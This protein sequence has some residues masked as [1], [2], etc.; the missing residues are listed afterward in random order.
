MSE[1]VGL[2]AGKIWNFLNAKGEV[3]VLV[4]KTKLGVPNSLLY[5]ALG[6]LMREEKI[7]IK[8]ERK[9]YRVGLH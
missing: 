6:W 1:Q 4:L 3:P 7:Y 8:K 2:L 5:L 9:D